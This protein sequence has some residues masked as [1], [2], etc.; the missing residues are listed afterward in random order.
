MSQVIFRRDGRLVLMM[1]PEDYRR[2][3]ELLKQLG[4]VL[5]E[6]YSSPCG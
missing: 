2:L 1:H 3:Q 4:I 6:E 5:E